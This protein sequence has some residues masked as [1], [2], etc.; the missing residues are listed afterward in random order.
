MLHWLRDCLN[1]P[2]P[3]RDTW[4]KNLKNVKVP[5]NLGDYVSV[6]V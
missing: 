1:L 6:L 2:I 5:P 4:D 3:Y